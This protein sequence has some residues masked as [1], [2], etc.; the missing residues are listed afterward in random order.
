MFSGF[1]R[2]VVSYF[3]ANLS[4]LQFLKD[5]EYGKL[6][7]PSLNYPQSSKLMTNLY[8]CLKL[9]VLQV[10]QSYLFYV[11]YKIFLVLLILMIDKYVAAQISNL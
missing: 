9:V 8:H 1:S 7:I 5:W 11:T 10:T 6:T 2:F 4:R 3:F